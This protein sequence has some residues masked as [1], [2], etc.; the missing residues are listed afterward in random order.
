MAK[1]VPITRV[2]KFFGEEDFNLDIEMGME[3]LGDDLNMSVVLYRIDRKKTKKD[4]IY[5]EAP[6]DGIVF[7]PP[8]EVKG[9]VQITESSLKQLG[10][11]KVEQ[12]E[13][14]NMKFSFYQK[15]LDDLKVELLKGDYLGYYVTED[16]VR[17]YSVIDDGIVNMDNKHTYAGYKPFYRSVIATFVNKNEF[18][19]L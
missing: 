5:G 11:S 15:Q 9:I 7:M 3:Y 4:D 16:K 8:V 10:N 1:L 14:G 18:R 17:Y 13:P 19:G 12:K 2:G 6:K